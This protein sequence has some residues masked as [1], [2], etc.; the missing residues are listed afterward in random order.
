MAL[1][2]MWKILTISV[3]LIENV[4]C[5]YIGS[6]GSI[7]ENEYQMDVLSKDHIN[8]RQ[9]KRKLKKKKLTSRNKV[10]EV[11]SYLG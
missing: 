9:A 3:V 1:T 10:G 7:I 8:H 2:K 5:T 4:F 6:N 11:Y